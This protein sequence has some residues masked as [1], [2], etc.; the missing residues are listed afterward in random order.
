MVCVLFSEIV[1]LL[2]DEWWLVL[3]A[4]SLTELQKSCGY[5]GTTQEES[6]SEASEEGLKF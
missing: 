3:F 6:L 4:W 1:A 5:A 2:V